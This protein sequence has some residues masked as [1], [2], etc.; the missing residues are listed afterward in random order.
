M[1]LRT[2]LC[3][4]FDAIVFI[5]RQPDYDP[6]QKQLSGDILAT[7]LTRTASNSAFLIQSTSIE[8]SRTLFP[9]RD[10]LQ[11]LSSFPRAVERTSI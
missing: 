6:I 11:L 1:Q 10:H 3:G 5:Y 8:D 9:R 2:R 4:G 7:S